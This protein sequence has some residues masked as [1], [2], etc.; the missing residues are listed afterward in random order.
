MF[1]CNIIR[2][3]FFSSSNKEYY[4]HIFLEE[5]KYSIK[6]RKMI[7]AINENLKLNESDDESDE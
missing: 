4:L 3:Y 1:I 6:N 2:F 5:C 7:N